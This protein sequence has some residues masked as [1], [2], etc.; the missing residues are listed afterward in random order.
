MA[1]L[2]ERR[3]ASRR[4]N[5]N[6]GTEETMHAD[7]MDGSISTEREDSDQR[8]MRLATLSHRHA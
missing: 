2:C 5:T 4:S 7:A 1:T 6:N 8:I 3:N